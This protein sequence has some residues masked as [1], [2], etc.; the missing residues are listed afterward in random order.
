M[1][2]TGD[3]NINLLACDNHKPTAD[4]YD[5]FLTNAFIPKIT[6]ATRIT[7]T[8]ATLIDHMFLN[9]N[10]KTQNSIAGTLTSSMTD[11]YMNFIFLSKFKQSYKPNYVS[12][13]R[14]TE[15]NMNTLKEAL[16]EQDYSD[17]YTTKTVML[18]TTK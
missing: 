14:L 18:L 16:I 9:E 4:Y 15:K 2:I 17:I 11:H 6:A 8:S 10:H 7:H 12:Y 5:T 3:T 13:R 1:L